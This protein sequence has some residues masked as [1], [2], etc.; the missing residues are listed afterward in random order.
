M[1]DR[2]NHFREEEIPLVCPT[3]KTVAFHVF[4]RAVVFSGQPGMGCPE[5][6]YSG[7]GIRSKSRRSRR[8]EATEATE[9]EPREVQRGLVEKALCLRVR[10]DWCKEPAHACYC[11]EAQTQ[12]HTGCA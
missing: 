10:Y 7:E 1:P 5:A 9:E 4:R 3:F 6:I 8:A 2:V 12:V 11:E